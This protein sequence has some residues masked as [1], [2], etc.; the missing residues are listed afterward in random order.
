MNTETRVESQAV[1]ASSRPERWH[2]INWRKTS[3]AVRK[4]QVRI[5]K[6]AQRQEWRRVKALQR[7]LT[8]SLAAKAL[9][10]RRVT[11]NRGRDTPGSG[12]KVMEYPENQMGGHLRYEEN[13]I[14]P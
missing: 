6:A 5:A 7:M 10:V 4:L 13:R 12:W 9:A 2:A 8:R 1:S 11:E 14:S 3:E